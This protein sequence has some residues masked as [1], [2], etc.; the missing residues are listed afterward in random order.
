M[1]GG[2]RS[3]RLAFE[4]ATRLVQRFGSL[5]KDGDLKLIRGG[6]QTGMDGVYE[7]MNS[8][9]NDGDVAFSGRD[10]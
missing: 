4:L 9:P 8:G 3:R 2:E 1:S 6:H 7:S 10:F 5:L